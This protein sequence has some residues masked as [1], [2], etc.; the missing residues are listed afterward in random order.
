MPDL[1]FIK[2]LAQILGVLGG[3]LVFL[4]G[5]W[6]RLSK[7]FNKILDKQDQFENDL[8]D[9]KGDIKKISE[10][11]TVVST[12]IEEREKQNKENLQNIWQ[13]ITSRKNIREANGS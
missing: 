9:L 12:R 13:T 4:I 8:K 11:V 3:G 7:V 10:Q 2:N 6:W 1:D 5:F